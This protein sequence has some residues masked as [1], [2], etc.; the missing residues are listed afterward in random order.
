MKNKNLFLFITTLGLTCL[1]S[2]GSIPE[3]R[4]F[5]DRVWSGH[6]VGFELRT[7]KDSNRQ[8]IAYYNEDRAMTIASRILDSSE[9]IKQILPSKV[10]WDSHNY[11]TMALDRDGQLHVTGNM[12]GQPLVYFKT[13]TPGDITTLKAIGK[14]VGT[15]ENKITYP[16]FLKREGGPLMFTY[17][18]GGSG[19]GVNFVN[20][21]SEETETWTRLLDVPLFDGGGKM[22]AYPGADFPKIGPDGFWHVSWVW[23]DNPNASSNH[24]LSYARTR[25]FQH[26]ETYKGTS[27]KLPITISTPDVIIDPIPVKGGIINGSGK[28][29]FDSRNR[30]IIAYHKFDK[31]GATQMYLTRFDGD[32]LTTRQITQW[33]YRWELKGFGSIAGGVSHSGVNYDPELGLWITLG[34]VR[35]GSGAWHLDEETLALG[36]QIPNDQLPDYVPPHIRGTVVA[37]FHL[38]ISQDKGI[39][40]LGKRFLLRWE[41]LP[42]NNDRPRPEPYP[43]PG[44][45]E[46]FLLEKTQ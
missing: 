5:V 37:P 25:D 29:G 15:E 31:D 7:D 35:H 16:R 24:D 45:L 27:I 10:G 4:I 41:T 32:K 14:M 2:G 13:E 19:N 34:N 39:P 12:H 23:R 40:L 26:W 28:I 36:K 3:G 42:V 17:R 11:I 30:L 44:N 43:E 1:L 9:F 18:H 6:P 20:I 46:L 33:T 22:N 38:H 8:Y 21:Y